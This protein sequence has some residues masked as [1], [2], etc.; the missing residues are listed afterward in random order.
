M[1]MGATLAKQQQL[2]ESSVVTEDASVPSPPLS[3]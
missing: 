2:N 1:W 3:G